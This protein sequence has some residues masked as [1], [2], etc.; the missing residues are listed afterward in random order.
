MFSVEINNLVSSAARLFIFLLNK[1][2][3]PDNLAERAIRNFK[4]KQKVSNLFK[5]SNGAHVHS[6]LRSVIDTAI[7][8][9]QNPLLIIKL[10]PQ[11]S[12]DWIVTNF[13]HIF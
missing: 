6:T 5:S 9:D 10:I 12:A 1:D 3:P 2:I 13:L 11:C 8:N 7:K 4:V